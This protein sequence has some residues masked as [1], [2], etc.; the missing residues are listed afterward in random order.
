MSAIE[1]A[2]TAREALSGSA[3]AVRADIERLTKSLKHILEE[4]EEYD[5]FIRMWEKLDSTSTGEAHLQPRPE[6]ITKV[7]PA[8]LS[9]SNPYFGKGLPGAATLV[10]RREKRAMHVSDITEVLVKNG[11][12]FAAKKPAMS[13]DWALK[14]AALK[15][16]VAKVGPSKWLAVADDTQQEAEATHIMEDG[17]DPERSARTQAGLSFARDRGVR[18]GRPEKITDDHRARAIAMLDHGKTVQEI[19]EHFGVHRNALS[20]RIVRWRAEGV[21]PEKK[22]TQKISNATQPQG[23]T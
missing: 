2:R 17:P 16:A 6:A 4:M 21:F 9:A 19:A 23:N 10:L 14:Q 18:L 1:K 8:V 22:Q 5:S 12:Q 20:R 11:F 15:G 3:N 13:V 7:A